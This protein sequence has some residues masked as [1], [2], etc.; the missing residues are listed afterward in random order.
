MSEQ[1]Y[2]AV[3]IGSG[4]AG[5]TA[6]LY[7]I[8]AGLKIAIV[9][10]GAVGGQVLLTSEL[11]N[12]PGFPR[13]I[14][15]WEMADLLDAHIQP[16]MPRR[17]QTKVEKLVLAQEK[18]QVHTVETARGPLSTRTI[19]VC[20][21]A[22]HKNLGIPAEK[23][24]YGKG[25]S[26][27]AVCDG[28]F[29]KGQ[30]VAVIGGGNSALEEA[31]YLSRIVK[32]IYLIHRR[33]EFRAAKIYQDKVKKTENITIITPTILEDIKGENG[34]EEIILKNLETQNQQIIPVAGV[35]IF[36]GTKP[37]ADFIPKELSSSEAGFIFTDAE[38]NTNIPGV[39]A[40]GDIR[41]KHC[42]QV[43]TAVGDGATAATAAI[44]YLELLNV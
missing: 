35:F 27:C 18:G 15:G 33:N 6:A 41:E 17:L 38:M 20:S 37:S 44:S 12:Y 42:K 30:E 31:L 34:V 19:I 3:V 14:K 7:L 2:D 43:S 11:E 32:H 16:Y 8:R 10:K 21:G 40:A 23:T 36:A 22:S 4:P 1:I 25:I 24:Y 29:Y 13:G 5:I 26:Y 9:E 39:F 28:N